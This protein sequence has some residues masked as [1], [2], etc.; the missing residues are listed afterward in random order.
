MK[1]KRYREY[2]RII[3]IH[4]HAKIVVMK[5]RER[6][7]WNKV[8]QHKSISSVV[9]D[10]V[11]AVGLAAI[12]TAMTATATFGKDT[13]YRANTEVKPQYVYS[14]SSDSKDDEGISW[15]LIP[16]AGVIAAVHLIGSYKC[17][18]C[19]E[20]KTNWAMKKKHPSEDALKRHPARSE[21]Q[22]KSCGYER[23]GNSMEDIR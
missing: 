3:G 13:S 16:I 9:K 21:Y 17:S 4:I 2:F 10:G 6:L 12:I 11:K 19:P 20:C 15:V 14:D 22:C 5:N 18:K 8:N 23:V 7:R 1:R